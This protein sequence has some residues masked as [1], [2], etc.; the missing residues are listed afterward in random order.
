MRIAIFLAL[1]A[2]AVAVPKKRYDGFK[3]LEIIPSNEAELL[4]LRKW[5]DNFDFWLE[6]TR[7]GSPV[8][9]MVGPQHQFY[10][11]AKLLAAGMTHTIHIADVQRH[12]DYSFDQ[13]AERKSKKPDTMAFDYNNFNTYEDYLTELDA[14]VADCPSGFT[15]T[16]TNIGTTYE[17]RDLR[18]LRVAKNGVDPNSRFNIWF[19]SMMHAREWLA[20]AT[21]MKVIDRLIRQYSTDATARRLLDTYDWYFLPQMNPDGYS[22]T[23]ATG[24]DRLW[25]K[26]RAPTKNAACTGTDLNRNYP[27]GWSNPG[28]SN[29]PCS[30]TYYGDSSASEEETQAVNN[31]ANTIRSNLVTWIN[32]HTYGQYWLTPWGDCSL[33]ADHTSHQLPVANA[34]AN[35][36]E[37]TYNTNWLRGNSCQVLYETSGS[38]IDQMKAAYGVRYAHTP[39]LRGNSFVVPPDQI[40]P[41]YTEVW[42]GIVAFI[43]EMERIGLP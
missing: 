18:V 35:A 41:S 34:A 40:Q 7:V 12:I 11:N 4:F 23:W 21:L 25:R 37:A 42:N 8:H 29:V 30:D 19:D 1:V 38:I 2:L 15:C 43:D 14:L 32:F 36:I 39:E 24:G 10:V 13:I 3:V 6:P 17:G 26:N 9:I 31:Y 5:M 22:Y 27:F 33:P 28:A 16:T 20:G